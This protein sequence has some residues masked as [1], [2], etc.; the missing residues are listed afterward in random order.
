MSLRLVLGHVSLETAV[1]SFFLSFISS[2]HDAFNLLV[3]PPSSPS[4]LTHPLLLCLGGEDRLEH[5]DV[6]PGNVCGGH[7]ACG[8]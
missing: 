3:I 2:F 6:C 4:P 1:L 5:M 8:Q 7:L